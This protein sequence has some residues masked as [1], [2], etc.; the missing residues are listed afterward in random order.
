MPKTRKITK[1]TEKCIGQWLSAMDHKDRDKAEDINLK[2]I[3]PV[4]GT[5]VLPYAPT[6]AEIDNPKRFV[7]RVSCNVKVKNRADGP[8]NPIAV[9]RNSVII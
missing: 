8:I 4:L 5:G 7:K 2:C 9:C 1:K 3:R 6:R